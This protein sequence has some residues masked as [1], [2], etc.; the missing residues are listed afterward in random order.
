MLWAVAYEVFDERFRLP[1]LFNHEFQNPSA[2]LLAGLCQ[3]HQT[4]TG[5]RWPAGDWCQTSDGDGMGENLCLKYE[6]RLL[7]VAMF[8]L[9]PMGQDRQHVKASPVLILHMTGG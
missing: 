7:D 1:K 5:Y 8:D 9:H 4:R 6:D 2:S 3:A